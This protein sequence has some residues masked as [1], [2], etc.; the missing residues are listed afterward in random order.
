MGDVKMTEREPDSSFPGR[1]RYAKPDT[2]RKREGT[3]VS[4]LI[5][6]ILVILL[7]TAAFYFFGF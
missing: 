7:G 6:T 2:P 5:G 4:L 1:D 3:N